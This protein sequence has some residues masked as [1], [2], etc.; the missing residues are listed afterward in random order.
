ML[1]TVSYILYQGRSM[2]PKNKYT[3]VYVKYTIVYFT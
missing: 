1:S 2:M 3:N